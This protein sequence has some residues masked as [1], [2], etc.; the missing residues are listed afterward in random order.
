MLTVAFTDDPEA[1]EAEVRALWG[2]PLCLVR[3]E[4]SYAELSRIQRELHDGAGRALGLQVLS[5]SVGEVANAVEISVVTID[6]PQR[7]ALD[8]RYGQGAVIVR[9]V[10]RPVR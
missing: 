7:A 10:L 3:H 9:P 4:R 1:H 5:S 8:E 6:D 2:G